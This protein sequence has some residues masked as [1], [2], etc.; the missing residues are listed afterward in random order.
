VVSASVNVFCEESVSASDLPGAAAGAVCSE[1]DLAVNFS[2]SHFALA[3]AL[4]PKWVS[5]CEPT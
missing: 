5:A 3:C 1:P 2:Y 4:W